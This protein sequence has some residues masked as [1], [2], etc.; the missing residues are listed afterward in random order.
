MRSSPRCTGTGYKP[1]LCQRLAVV[2]AVERYWAAA[3]AKPEA[4]RETLL[5]EVGLLVSPRASDG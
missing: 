5:A 4:E 2:D 1:Y 3:N